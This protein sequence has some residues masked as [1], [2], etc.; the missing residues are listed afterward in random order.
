LSSSEK[1]DEGSD[2][3]MSPQHRLYVFDLDGTVYRGSEVIPHAAEAINQLVELGAVVRYFTNNSAARPERVSEKLRAMGV[4][5]EPSWVY[6]TGALAARVCVE[7][8]FRSV[9]LVGEPELRETLA[10]AGVP[11]S[12][13]GQAD[14]VVVGICRSLTYEL[15][16]RASALVRAGAALVVTNRDATYPIEGGREQPG[17]GAIAAAVE[18]ASGTSVVELGKPQ[19]ALLSWILADCGVA[20]S[21]IL[22]VGDRYETDI[23]SGLN[24]GCDVSMVLTGVTQFAPDGVPVV[25]DL[26]G[27]LV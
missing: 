27:L 1:R 9:Y 5:C 12:D 15:L 4:P 14:C 21:E 13:G 22:V 18:T 2:R 20:P 24:A 8:G 25:A 10:E 6:G 11:L 17:A 16:D 3:K 23:V 7:R 19:T 26:R